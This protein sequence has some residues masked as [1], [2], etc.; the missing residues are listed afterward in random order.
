MPDTRAYWL[1]CLS[2]THVGTGRGVGYIDLPLY[3]DATTDWPAVPGSSIKGVWA[4][5]FHREAGVKRDKREEN[6]LLKAAF[7]TAGT[8]TSTAGALIATDARLVC[9]P[10]RS[11]KGTFAWATSPLALKFMRRDLDLA[12]FK[13][14]PKAPEP[15]GAD[16]ILI[17]KGSALTVGTQVALEEFDLVHGSDENTENWA[18]KLAGWVFRDAAWRTEFK[19]RFAI[20]PDLLFD[21]FAATGT[22]VVTRVKIDDE[23]KTVVGGAL[24]TEEALPAESILW[25]LVQCD[26][27]PGVDADGLVKKYASGELPL[28]IGGK[29]SVGRGKARLVF[30]EGK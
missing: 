28:Q 8:E 13:G 19:K 29:A 23:K 11:F 21:H 15:T 9:L 22:E 17:P 10:V 25:G 12:G 30:S 6:A 24:W 27:R 26:P 4:D 7:G 16:S 18:D 5:H 3:R 14:L 2:P 1:H 20:L